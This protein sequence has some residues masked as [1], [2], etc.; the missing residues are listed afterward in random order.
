MVEI[1][2]AELKGNYKILWLRY[3]YGVNLSTHC[4]R[5]LLGHNDPRVHGYMKTLTNLQLEESRY[6]YLCGVDQDFNWY[7]NLHLAF[8][9]SLGSVIE[10]DNEFI[11]CRIVNAK[12]LPINDQYIDWS[13]PQS[14]DRLFCTCRNWQFANYLVSR[15]NVTQPPRQGTL[16]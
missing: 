10:L 14:R 2:Y 9:R 3:I 1:E 12:Q 8:V 7:K 15:G 16:F 4:M 11:R 5:C 13:L 6:Y